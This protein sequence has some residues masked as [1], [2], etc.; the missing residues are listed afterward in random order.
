MHVEVEAGEYY[1]SMN[2]WVNGQL[3]TCTTVVVESEIETER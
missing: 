2:N 3:K 1:N